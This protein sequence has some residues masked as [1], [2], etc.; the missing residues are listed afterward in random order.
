MQRL[1]SDRIGGWI[2]MYTIWS[3]RKE[4]RTANWG[5]AEWVVDGERGRCTYPPTMTEEEVIE[6]YQKGE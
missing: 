4:T 1:I 2:E 3:I 5:G 6:A